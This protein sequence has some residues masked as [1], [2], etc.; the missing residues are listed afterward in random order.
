VPR[1]VDPA[2]GALCSRN[3]SAAPMNEKLIQV[4]A[5]MHLAYAPATLPRKPGVEEISGWGLRRQVRRSRFQLDLALAGGAEPAQSP[6]LMLRAVQLMEMKGRK[7]IVKSIDRLVRL[8]DQG[9]KKQIRVTDDGN[10]VRAP[11]RREKIWAARPLLVELSERVGAAGAES[12][13]GVAMA[14]V[15]INDGGGP[16]FDADTSRRLQRAAQ[17]ALKR[18][19]A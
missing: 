7:Q 19:A 2:A 13:Q 11:L 9:S 16:L 1:S 10:S 8:V 3:A 15:L 17:A 18:I 14:S 4:G 12:L 6:D 5:E